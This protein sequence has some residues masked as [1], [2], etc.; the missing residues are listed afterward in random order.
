MRRS[1]APVL[2]QARYGEPLIQHLV[3]DEDEY[4][5]KDWD[6]APAA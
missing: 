5:N 2:R 6:Y 3:L 4:R 1:P